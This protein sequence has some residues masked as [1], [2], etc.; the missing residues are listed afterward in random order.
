M[1]HEDNLI[2]TTTKIMHSLQMRIVNFMVL[3]SVK[4]TL[5]MEKN[6]CGTL[7]PVNA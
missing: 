7:I 1:I 5:M 2:T 6:V 3:V 4:E